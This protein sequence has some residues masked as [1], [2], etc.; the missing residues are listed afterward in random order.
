MARKARLPQSQVPSGAEQLRGVTQQTLAADVAVGVRLDLSA[1]HEIP[2]SLIDHHQ[3]PP[4]TQYVS[5][6]LRNSLLI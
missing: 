3:P 1:C 4:R 2:L 5:L 6:P